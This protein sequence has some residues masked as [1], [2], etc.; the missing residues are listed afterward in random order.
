MNA[1]SSSLAI[2]FLF[3]TAALA[4]CSTYRVVR[5]TPHGGEVALVGSPD[6]ARE[7]AQGY[8]AAQCPTGFDILEEGEAVIGEESTAQTTRGHMFGVP[9]KTTTESTTEKREWR[10]KYQCKDAPAASPVADGAGA[11]QGAIHELVVRF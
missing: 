11:K 1:H 5:V 10:I 9:T 4:G 3:A 6:G 7:K 8:M 2:A